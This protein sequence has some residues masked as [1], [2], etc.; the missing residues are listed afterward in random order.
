MQAFGDIDKV[1]VFSR[2]PAGV[3]IVKFQTASAAQRCIAALHG[4]DR[5]PIPAPADTSARTLV[6]AATPSPRPRHNPKLRAFY[7]DGSTDYTYPKCASVSSLSSAGAGGG[8]GGA[9]RKREGAGAEEGADEQGRGRDTRRSG[10]VV[11]ADE[12]G[13]EEDEEERRISDF[14]DWLER[15]EDELPEEF[16]LRT[17][18]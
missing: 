8:G 3:T 12:E 16:R 15:T 13:D 6:L 17:E 7:W 18:G 11:G 1:T 4:R 14:G 2:H 9:K 5:H 10:G